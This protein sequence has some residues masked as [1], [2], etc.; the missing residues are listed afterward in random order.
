M[1][2]GLRH[3]RRP[4]ISSR[5][6]PARVAPRHTSPAGAPR[7]RRRRPPRPV[8]I[9][10]GLVAGISML[11][12]A[13]AT[14][15]L[16]ADISANL[17]GTTLDQYLPTAATT[18][19]VAATSCRVSWTPPAATPVDLSYDLTNGAG[20]ILATGETGVTALVTVPVTA[21][22]PTVKARLQS[23]ISPGETVV[24]AP[25]LGWP[26][27][28][29]D[30]QVAPGDQRLDLTWTAPNGNGGTVAS[31]TAALSPGGQTCSV[32][33][34]TT[35]CAFTGLTNAVTY[36]VSVVA[37]SEVGG[38]PAAT[39]S[40]T[41]TDHTP[42]APT[43]TTVAPAQQ[44]VEVGWTAP[45]S[46]GG[47]PVTGYTATATPADPGLP[48]RTC[49]AA[50][51]PCTVTGLTDGSR[52][53]VTVTASNLYGNGPG[54]TG[55]T[56]ISYPSSILTNAR[57]AVWL[58]AAA[59]GSLFTD[60]GC[61]TTSGAGQPVGCWTDR[62]GHGRHATQSGGAE[63][64]TLTVVGG[65]AV[66]GFDGGDRLVL[67][68]LPTG[69]DSSASFVVARLDDPAPSG[70]GVRV[71]HGWG[72]VTAGGTRTLTK[73]NAGSDAALQSDSL[74]QV[75]I[76]DWTGATWHQFDDEWTAAAGG[77]VRGWAAGGGRPTQTS[78][79]YGFSTSS[80]SGAVGDGPGGGAG[81]DGPVAE[82]IVLA[83]T[84]T[85]S[86]RRIVQEYL[87]RKWGHLV[88]PSAPSSATA[89]A[90]GPTSIAVSWAAPQWDGGA[91]VTGYTATAEPS[92]ATCSTAGTSCTIA[93]LALGQ[94]YT[95]MVTANN[96]VGTGPVATTS[97]ASL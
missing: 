43:G 38:S 6:V 48:T 68:G 79:G 7:G 47:S 65:Q 60:A 10:A 78:T 4:L 72:T 41:P 85:D 30:L 27:A 89:S 51:S 14:F 29:A 8:L 97:A 22:T 83:G 49:S 46:D 86:E 26:D 12:Q 2:N 45:A 58:D 87:A 91:P 28:P 61:S 36:S 42:G 63:R 11:G 77:T 75:S 62:S 9:A 21:V 66:P 53:T 88:A 19:R 37:T 67:S 57:P 59:P 35:A 3:A 15:G 73:T 17:T 33:V 55:V 93:G 92:G 95:V 20:G 54:S 23:W 18:V 5:R 31:Y 16:S 90:A 25:C 39:G 50:G 1:G 64:P 69:T 34:P 40:G 52:Y 81:W 32:N 56:A 76:G 70:S 84:V 24:D 80:G 44:Q 74:G 82:L 94:S 13:G 71:V 96:P